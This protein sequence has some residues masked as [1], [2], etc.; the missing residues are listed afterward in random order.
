MLLNKFLNCDKNEQQELDFFYNNFTF[1]HLCIGLKV[2]LSH[3]MRYFGIQDTLAYDVIRLFPSVPIFFIASGFLVSA[4]L[5]RS[6]S[7]TDYIKGRILRIYPALYA[8]LGMSLIIMFS[9]YSPDIEFKKFIFW[10]L[11]Q[12]TI[13]QYYNPDFFRGYGMGVM[14]GSLWSVSVQMQ[15]YLVLPLILY[16]VKQYR[17]YALWIGL[18][19][20]LM[21]ANYIF[22]SF[23]KD[24]TNRKLLIVKLSH[25]T[26]LPHLFLFLTGVFFQHNLDLINR[27]LKNNFFVFAILYIICAIISAKLGLRY[28]GAEFNPVLALCLS[29]AMFSFAYSYRHIFANIGKGYDISYGLYVYHMPIINMFMVLNIFSPYLNTVFTVLVSVI[30]ATLSLKFLEKPIMQ[31]K[32]QSQKNT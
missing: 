21:L 23:F 19:V 14:N 4:S 9:L 30:I 18:F 17:N 16:C 7:Y 28:Q 32:K 20:A 26:V 10:L 2:V 25:I 3:S 6:K 29:L 12:L 5:S 15:F 24:A 13:F 31:L 27:Y 11:G 1:I 8:S 22:Y